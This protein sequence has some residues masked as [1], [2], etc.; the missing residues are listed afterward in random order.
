MTSAKYPVTEESRG[1][2]ARGVN[3]EFEAGDKNTL[4]RISDKGLFN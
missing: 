1:V 3:P 2:N 4:C